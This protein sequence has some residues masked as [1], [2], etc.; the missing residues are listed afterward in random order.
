MQGEIG[1][2]SKGGRE[3]SRKSRKLEDSYGRGMA[4]KAAIEE[5][6]F[7]C[8]CFAVEERPFIKEE[9]CPICGAGR[10]EL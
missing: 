9:E 3:W 1:N 2:K 4:H 10:E 8:Q 6:R 5:Q 7:D